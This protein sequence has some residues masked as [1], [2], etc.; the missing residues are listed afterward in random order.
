MWA[1]GASTTAVSTGPERRGSAQL[2]ASPPLRA[3][4]WGKLFLPARSLSV[5]YLGISPL[6]HFVARVFW[7]CSQFWALHKRFCPRVKRSVALASPKSD[8]GSV[9]TYASL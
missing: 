9:G 5:A 1:E 3:E 2:P 4:L 7:M 6:Q 8:V